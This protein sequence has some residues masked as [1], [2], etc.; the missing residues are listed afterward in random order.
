MNHFSRYVDK[1]EKVAKDL[2]TYLT[3]DFDKISAI[4]RDKLVEL[5]INSLDNRENLAIHVADHMSLYNIVRL[6]QSLRERLVESMFKHASQN[7]NVARFLYCYGLDVKFDSM[8]ELQSEKILN[9]MLNHID[10][11]EKFAESIAH[12]GTWRRSYNTRTF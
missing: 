11:N 1:N 8:S 6:P 5:L 9:I 7:S 3:R 2:F 12:V 4:P 10:N